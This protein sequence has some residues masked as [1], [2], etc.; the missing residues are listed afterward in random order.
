MCRSSHQPT[1]QTKR[2]SQ[3]IGTERI[4]A[5][6]L[7]R[8]NWTKRSKQL[9]KA[10]CPTT[11]CLLVKVNGDSYMHDTSKAFEESSSA[12][13]QYCAL[14]RFKFSS[15]KQV[16]LSTRRGRMSFINW[17]AVSWMGW[18]LRLG[19]LGTR[20]RDCQPNRTFCYS[21]SATFAPLPPPLHASGLGLMVARTAP[22]E[23]A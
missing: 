6:E 1:G 14:Q 5:T 22:V 7:K 20:Y 16:A 4:K 23:G 2:R 17:L 13:G 18:T 9:F 10:C 8:S 11:N 21:S 3:D 19:G 12:S 15:R